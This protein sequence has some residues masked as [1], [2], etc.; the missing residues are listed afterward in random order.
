[1]E[2]KRYG[3][4]ARILFICKK[5][6]SIDYGKG[7]YGLKNSA[8]FVASALGR[9]GYDTSVA[10]VHDNN[11]IDRVVHDY[12]P[13]HVFIHALWV[14]PEKFHVL[15]SKYPNI[16]WNIRVH[17]K[18]P[19][20][21]TEGIAFSWL[22]QYLRDI[23]PHYQNFSVSFNSQEG[24]DDVNKCFGDG[25]KLVK[26]LPNIYEQVDAVQLYRFPEVFPSKNSLHISCFG[27]LRPMKNHVMQAMAAIVFSNEKNKNLF[28]HI[29]GTRIER[30]GQEPLN[31]LH[32]IFND[33]SNSRHR[34]VEHGWLSHGDFLNLA[35]S[36]DIGMQV[37]LSESY[38]IVA[39][40]HTWMGVPI[41]ASVD[42]DWASSLSTCDP[43]DMESILSSLRF[44]WN[45]PT[46]NVLMNRRGL[47]K[48]N[49]R[50]IWLWEND[51]A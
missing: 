15:L 6:S 45:F 21:A 20:L 7:T 31:N 27:A 49:D 39:A 38:N 14:V 11:C 13:T 22:L 12:K 41:V 37:S 10:V 1:M 3:N 25:G 17:S 43:N 18:I 46:L 48:A 28:F 47:K 4:K 30:G 36:M 29:N 44:A 34:L 23:Q 8:Q 2:Q 35:Q 16:K 19:F 40:D 32:A 24:A 5:R 50:A 33:V 42:I 26:Y 9:R 51:L